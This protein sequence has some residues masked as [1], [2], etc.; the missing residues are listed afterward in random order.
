[1][2]MNSDLDLFNLVVGFILLCVRTY[3][4]DISKLI[5]KFY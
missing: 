3:Y 5:F 4:Y 1:M 2:L